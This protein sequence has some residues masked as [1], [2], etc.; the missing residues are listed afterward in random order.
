MKET[1]STSQVTV[2]PKCKNILPVIPGYSTWC[3]RCNW[4]IIPDDRILKPTWQAKISEW[5]SLKVLSGMYREICKSP[6]PVSRWNLSRA[7]VSGL[8]ILILLT[9]LILTLLGLTLVFFGFYAWPLFIPAAIC[10]LFAWLLRPRFAKM[11][12][13]TLSPSDHP[14][15]F[16]LIDD[17]CKRIGT[18]V[19]RVVVSED[20]YFSILYVGWKQ[21][22]ILSIG[23]PYWEI[24]TKEERVAA[25]T[26][27]LALVQNE[28]RLQIFIISSAM[29]TLNG[30]ADPFDLD[31]AGLEQLVRNIIY[32]PIGLTSFLM[33]FLWCQ[34][35]QRRVFDADL[36]AAR[37]AGTTAT[38][39]MIKKIHY[40]QIISQAVQRH[41]M[42]IGFR[43]IEPGDPKEVFAEITS[44]IAETPQRELLRLERIAQMIPP[45]IHAKCPPDPVR[46]ALLDEHYNSHPEIQVNDEQMARID[47]SFAG[48]RSRIGAVLMDPYRRI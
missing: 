39:R 6:E 40:Q 27:I 3:D 36:A 4:N 10:L 23:L 44:A 25:L 34:D 11:P 14:E 30:W 37:L 42:K 9:T 47:A 21:E 38:I 29:Q 16:Q 31:L 26:Q 43:Q 28:T 2:C 48:Y 33:D 24:L 13:P 22:K 19:D 20:L 46:L 5:I 41:V 1:H 7:L 15:L 18:T 35:F 45:S 17:I 8:S 32:S 12:E